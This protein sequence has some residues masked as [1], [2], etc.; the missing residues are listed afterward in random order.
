M[1]RTNKYAMILF[2]QIELLR[3]MHR[4]IAASC[5]GTP[6]EFSKRM[7]VSDRHLRSIIEEMKDMGAPINYSRRNATYYYTTP[8]EI[9]V[10]C[11]FRNLSV[12]EQKNISAGAPFFERFLLYGFF[13]AVN[14]PNFASS[15]GFS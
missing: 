8:F 11:I 9:D 14:N 2:K 6:G 7:K 3:R 4:L 1:E 12:E 15:N 5:T 13:C 10:I